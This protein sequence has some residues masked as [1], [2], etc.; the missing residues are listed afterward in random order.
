MLKIGILRAKGKNV[1]FLEVG[2]SRPLLPLIHS[3]ELELFYPIQK[4]SSNPFCPAV[5]VFVYT[6]AK[7]LKNAVY[8]GG[9]EFATPAGGGAGD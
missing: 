1:P 3:F 8:D 2:G 9:L 5:Y 6:Q 7:F 4:E